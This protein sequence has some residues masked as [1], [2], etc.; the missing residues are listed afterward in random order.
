M[1]A[2][3]IVAADCIALTYAVTTELVNGAAVLGKAIGN[4]A[5]TA[6]LFLL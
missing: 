5:S 2:R 1:F 6:A 4:L 3:I